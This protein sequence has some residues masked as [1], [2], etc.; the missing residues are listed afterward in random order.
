MNY[1]DLSGQWELQLSG[2]KAD[3]V[4][5]PGTLDG[6]GVGFPDAGANQWH[7]DAG[8]GNEKDML[9]NTRILTRLTRRNT[10][11]GPA[12]FTKIFQLP[13]TEERV[14][15][16]VERSRQLSLHMKGREV[17]AFTSGTIS[18]P[19]I[20]EITDY[21]TEGENSCTFCCDNSYPDWPHDA[22]VYSSA[23]T[24][25]TQTNWNGLLGYL[26]LRL[27]EKNFIT[28]IRIYPG[29]TTASVVVELDL[30]ESYEGFLILRSEAFTETITH[31][32]AKT[33]GRH[34][35]EIKDI[36]ISENAIPWDEFEPH[37]YNLSVSGERLTE[38]SVSF[39]IRTFHNL[40]GKL[41]L[42]GRIIFL[43]SES[44]CCVF[45]ENGHMPMSKEEWTKVL[46][47]YESYGINCMRFHSH[48]PPEA[49]FAAADEMGMLMQPELSH[50]NPA[51]AFEDDKSWS[52]Y[53]EELQQIL[54]SYA[55]HPSFVMLTLGNELQA[56][57]LGHKRMDLLLCLAKELDHTRMYANASNSH[58]G[59]LGPDM[60]SD[61]YTSSNYYK[62]HIRGTSANM[63]GYINEQYPNS[64]TNFDK[65]MQKVREEYDKPVFNFEVGQY[66]VLPDFDE[67]ND[68]KGVTSPENLLYIK[69]RVEARGLSS[70]WKTYVEATGELSL[71]AYREEV[72]A[73]LR[74][75]DM[76]GISLLGLQDFPGQ[77]TALV[78]MLNSHLKPKPY[79]FAQPERFR[80]FM[81]DVVPL[82][83]M[84]KYTY[85][86]TEQLTCDIKIAN[87][88]NKA[89]AISCKVFLEHSGTL[90]AEQQLE[91][92]TCPKGELTAAGSIT[93]PF[94]SQT[95][96]KK[97]TLKIQAGTYENS[98]PIWVYPDVP[99]TCPKDL[100]L[101][102]SLEEAITALQKGSKVFLSPP[103]T[104]EHFPDSIKTQFTT[105][106]WSVGTFASQDGFMGCLMDPNHPV[107]R[108]FPTEFHAN[109]QWWPMCQGRAVKLPENL[110]PLITA[111]DC[112]ARMRKMGML[113]EAKTG[114]GRLIISTMG[115][116]E[117]LHYPEVTALT[118][119][120]VNYMAS[121]DFH[122]VEELTE[123]Q[124]RIIVN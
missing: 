117:Q 33:S 89:Y 30:S 116:L 121:Q 112:Y 70:Q 22:I 1:I 57:A 20:F 51:T 122:P 79:A 60:H 88:S 82:G 69:E 3:S 35:V 17:P 26:R 53:K 115:L 25:E 64:R 48:C 106:F 92:V 32:I 72:E 77:G 105:D 9:G 15:L 31:P 16:E 85:R 2:H 73:V 124:L 123:E 87:Y 102:Q 91:T 42:N 94:A 43:R 100:L 66:E 80:Q 65:E 97:I 55:N 75:R 118:Q 74:T 38:K 78:G 61:F 54:I 34:T 68:F 83:L 62:E 81:K 28:N 39:G 111:L 96:A 19:H 98:Y 37:L 107:F 23:A 113:L 84:D 114:K 41:A 49:A 14:F 7:P 21:I 101:T 108:S 52:Y 104:S 86:D 63:T 11:E 4:N 10:Y 40:N 58:Y 109:W 12:Y 110:T 71:L 99:L 47:V 103:A 93:F 27:E 8:L 13:K 5:L 29:L 45:P 50:W 67:C 56:G 18:T 36:K 95:E 120:I 90:L 59:S 44:N 76:S 119:S 46:S 24:D 6:N